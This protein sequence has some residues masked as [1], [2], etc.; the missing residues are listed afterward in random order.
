MTDDQR[1]TPEDLAERWRV[2]PATLRNWRAL[3]KGP[4]FVRPSRSGVFYRLADVIAYENSRTVTQVK[5]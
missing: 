3:R 5:S 1:L 2:S 4:A